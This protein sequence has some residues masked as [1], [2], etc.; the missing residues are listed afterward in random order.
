MGY[1]GGP[2]TTKTIFTLTYFMW[3]VSVVQLVIATLYFWYFPWTRMFQYTFFA[4]PATYGVLTSSRFNLQWW[5]F[6]LTALLI[7]VLWFIGWMNNH[8]LSR[9]TKIA[10]LTMCSVELALWLLT[11]GISIWWLSDRNNPDF[12][13]NPANSYKACCTPEFYNT[14]G[15]CPNFGAPMP[16]CNPG[17]NLSELGTTWDFIFF[18]G[19][20]FA[21]CIIY[22]LYLYLSPQIM[23]ET[24]GLAQYGDPESTLPQFRDLWSRTSGGP[25]DATPATTNSKISLLTNSAASRD[26]VRAREIKKF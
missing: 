4:S 6:S 12:P 23:W 24:D 21:M 17:I 5:V 8:Y 11:F 19:V 2:G 22:I 14:V 15:S 16:E 13:D 25:V 7:P 26:L 3:Y 20:T 10:W 18:F 1:Q 9:G